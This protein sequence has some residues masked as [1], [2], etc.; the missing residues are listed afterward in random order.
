[1]ATDRERLAALEV[2]VREHD[3]RYEAERTADQL[4]VRTADSAVKEI[5]ELHNGL[6]RK[7]D[8][9]QKQFATKTELGRVE[10]LQSKITGGMIVLG[11]IGITNL[12]K[13]WLG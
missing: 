8:S 7:M 3:R 4:A 10:K 13:L 5:T 6:I 12:A 9:Q 2:T 11:V 1:L